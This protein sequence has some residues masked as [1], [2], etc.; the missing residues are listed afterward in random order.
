M[1]S[2]LSGTMKKY[3]FE[4][5]LQY[6]YEKCLP[7]K[8]KGRVADYIPELSHVDPMQFGI[9][10]QTNDG[11]SYGYG[12]ADVPFSIQSISKVFVLAMILPKVRQSFDRVHVEPSGDP[13]NSLVQL[14]YE[15]GVPRNPFINAGALVATDML[16]ENESDPQQALLDFVE[17]L[18]GGVRVDFNLDVAR[19]EYNTA[20]RNRSMAHLMKSFNNLTN[21][22]ETLLSVYCHHCSIEMSLKQLTLAFSMLA[23]GGVVP[24]TGV[25]LLSTTDVKRINALM[26]TCGFYDES[27]EFAFRVGLP[28][29]SGVGGGIVTV[30]PGQFTLAAWS[31]G[32][33]EKGNSLVGMRA[34]EMFTNRTGLSLF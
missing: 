13:F 31:P 10:L 25:R 29:K 24:S 20:E 28:G 33:N 18:T 7:Y 16:L 12:D 3:D 14:E 21:D 8:G 9:C 2:V 32:L 30:F 6:V 19:S 17:Q 27:G 15:R 22:V 23:N 26:L 34:L 11:H 5:A 4:G 1:P